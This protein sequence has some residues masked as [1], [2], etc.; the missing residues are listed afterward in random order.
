VDFATLAKEYGLPFALVVTGLITL[1]RGDVMFRREKAEQDTRHAEEKAAWDAE[2][3][4]VRAARDEKERYIEARRVEERRARL[5]AEAI[6]K[7][8]IDATSR[9]MPQVLDVLARLE[10]DVLRDGR[11]A[12]RPPDPPADRA[13]HE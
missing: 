1:A 4:K 5:E 8:L 12:P 10:R 13:A 7:A 9:S 3:K 2:L 6:A 11:P